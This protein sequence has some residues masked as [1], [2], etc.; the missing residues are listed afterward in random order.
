MIMQNRIRLEP[1][2]RRTKKLYDMIDQVKKEEDTL[3]VA[4]KKV[5]LLYEASPGAIYKDYEFMYSID[6]EGRLET[7]RLQRSC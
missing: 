5:D 1:L 4:E 3:T 6:N 2:E 7:K